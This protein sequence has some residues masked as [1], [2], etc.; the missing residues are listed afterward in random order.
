V[1]SDINWLDVP[2]WVYLLLGAAY[3]IF[4]AAKRGEKGITLWGGHV[5]SHPKKP[6]GTSGG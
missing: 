6:P 3:L 2:F 5:G 4:R 1:V